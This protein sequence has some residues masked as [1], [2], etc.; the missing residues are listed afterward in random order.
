[1]V[2]TGVTARGLDVANVKHVINYDLPSTQHD[3]ITEYVHRIGRTA[4]IGNEGR[5]T[6]FFNDRNEDIGEDLVKL[7]LESK[8]EVPDFLQ[9]HMPEDP[10]KIEW[11]DGTDDESDDGLGGGFG[12]VG[13]GFGGDIGDSGGF[14]GGD[15]GGFSGGEFAAEGD[16]N[17]KTASW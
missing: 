15:A 4:R 10:S 8:Q 6:S 16:N 3:G 14:D 1:M 13:G 7:L 9:Q 11:H 17:D 5:A 2:A 12:D